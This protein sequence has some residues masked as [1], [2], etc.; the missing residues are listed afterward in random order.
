MPNA[1]MYANPYA[2]PYLNPFLNPMMTQT[3]SQGNVAL[4]FFAA[5]QANGGI[6]SGRLSGT[7]PAP[8]SASTSAST[9]TTTQASRTERRSSNTPGGNAAR[10]FNRA[11]QTPTQPAQF[12]NRQGRFYPSNHQ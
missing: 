8:A 3:Q 5:Q 6:G 4:Y 2:N 11:Q 1:S 9:S 10:Y 7:R 12:Y